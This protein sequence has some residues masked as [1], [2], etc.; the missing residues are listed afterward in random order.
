MKKRV[1]RFI[2]ALLA[3]S[4]LAGAMG[5]VVLAD[6]QE[7]N[8]A[9][10]SAE[11][12]L[13]SGLDDLFNEATT[14][15]EPTPEPT[16]TPDPSVAFDNDEYYN[17][18]MGLLAALEVFTGY[19]DGSM[20]PGSTITR[21]EMA[22]VILKTLN[23]TDYVGYDNAFTDIAAG[24]WHAN[25]VQTA[26]NMNIV[27]GMGDG[28]FA[29]NSPVTYAQ[30]VKM[31]VCALGYGEYAEYRGGWPNGYIAAAS[32]VNV[33]KNAVGAAD[34]PAPR[35]LVAKLV[36]NALMTDYPQ[37]T[38]FEGDE[39]GNSVPVYVTK[40]DETLA[41]VKHDIKKA[42]GVIEVTSGAS[43]VYSELMPEGV[44]MIS[45]ERFYD[46]SGS[47]DGL[48]AHRATI[49]YHSDEVDN[50]TVIYANRY[51]T[52]TLE[53]N[54]D[55][56][57][58]FEVKGIDIQSLS[59]YPNGRRS[60]SKRI[61]KF[62]NPVVVYNSQYLSAADTGSESYKDFITP[63][64]GSVKL[65]DND[66]DGDYEVV[67]VDK[68][69]IMTVTAATAKK[70]TGKINNVDNIII[71]VDTDVDG[72]TVRV[73][74][75]GAE[76]RTRNINQNEVAAIK[77]S[78]SSAGSELIEIVV[79]G[80][81]VS[82]AVSSVEYDDNDNFV[83]YIN[84][85]KYIVDE[86]AV[87]DISINAQSE[88]S[89]DMFGRIGYVDGGSGS[90]SGSESY[91]WLM[92]FYED[93]NGGN[94]IARIYAEGGVKELP[95]AD[96]VN[97]RAP[98][99][100][101]TSS[102]SG[103]AIDDFSSIEFMSAGNFQVRLC[104]FST[105]SDNE[106][107]KLIF[108]SSADLSEKEVESNDRDS[109][110]FDWE[111]TDNVSASG[112]L[113]GGFFMSAS[114]I[115]EL[116]V[117]NDSA[118]FNDETLYGFGTVNSSQYLTREGNGITFIA[119][120]VTDKV[121]AIVIR[122]NKYAANL[123]N[124]DVL[125]K[126]YT[127]A[128]HATFMLT[129]ISETVNEDNEPIYQLT[130]YAGG[131]QVKFTTDITTSVYRL[132]DDSA[133]INGDMRYTVG[134]QLWNG[135]NSEFSDF[136]NHVKPGD[137]FSYVSNGSKVLSL[138]KIIDIDYLTE[139]RKNMFNGFVAPSESRD[140]IRFGPIGT[141]TFGLEGIVSAANNWEYSFPTSTSIDAVSIKVNSRGAATGEA[142]VFTKDEPY[143]VYDLTPY[144]DY[145]DN[146]G[147]GD[148]IF[149]RTFRGGLREIY[150]YRFTDGSL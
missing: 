53:I 83:A 94:V 32:R 4:M 110:W 6:E 128:D 33:T 14:T 86:N 16:P 104:K 17:E 61:T 72:R 143:D 25:I 97:L 18:A 114:N 41:F 139:Q 88:F 71:D 62:D 69:E 12:D 132:A 82:G 39:N 54:A 52:D 150:V 2:S 96:K 89:L 107:R 7:V 35:G 100:N 65:I 103:A 112:S 122:L 101:T 11:D 10:S 113:A 1:A 136:V 141:V 51:K 142:P 76:A 126:G 108:A 55:D 144:D 137:V 36:Y 115:K 123:P 44:V 3:A 95:L 45:G 66:N 146:A 117:P 92:K 129:K 138:I 145:G 134:E 48:I 109:F 75:G 5:A 105:N 79:T 133:G 43:M 34:D 47:L 148:F 90:L 19:E 140:A 57:I 80:E 40:K 31:V 68:Y 87:K 124:T 24:D 70:L 125:D 116:T 106:I 13:L 26:V 120:D 64:V 56:L 98:G 59:Y 119:A 60:S 93:D 81:K 58:E 63:K 29:P 37:F 8:A 67:M 74:K 49:Y 27:S 15:P 9:E 73:T 118:N 84:G 30:A 38:G 85:E 111:L 50:K 147:V 149:I 99:K 23:V 46:K 127:S 91:G 77:R 20:R 42:D 22:T 28:T 102:V 135:V 131:A 21:A 130:G 78:S 121:P